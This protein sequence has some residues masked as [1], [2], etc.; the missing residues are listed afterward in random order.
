MDTSVWCCIGYDIR[1]ESGYDEMMHDLEQFIGLKYLKAVHVND[2]RG[3]TSNDINWRL[4]RWIKQLCIR[5]APVPINNCHVVNQVS[6]TFIGQS[7]R[8]TSVSWYQN[9]KPVW[10]LVQQKE[11]GEG[12]DGAVW[13]CKVHRASNR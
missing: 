8:T 9:D 6:H 13:N 10:I 12:D 5:V 11:D 2:S 3:E 4:H 1:T 7:T